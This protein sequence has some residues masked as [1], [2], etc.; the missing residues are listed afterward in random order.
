VLALRIQSPLGEDLS[1]PRLVIKL[2]SEFHYF[3]GGS[4]LKMLTS[5]K[6]SATNPTVT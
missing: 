2:D 1:L 6:L 5:K 3:S 4:D